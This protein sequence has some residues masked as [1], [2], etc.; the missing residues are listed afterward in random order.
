LSTIGKAFPV[1]LLRSRAGSLRASDA[2]GSGVGRQ[3]SGNTAQLRSATNVLS[4]VLKMLGS[5]YR[6]AAGAALSRCRALRPLDHADI[7]DA[8]GWRGRSG[9]R[10]RINNQRSL[11]GAWRRRPEGGAYI[12]LERILHGIAAG[13]HSSDPIA[14]C[15]G[16]CHVAKRVS[17]RSRKPGPPSRF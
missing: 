9:H 7:A 11:G 16:R 2:T 10:E 12:R 8:L 3:R 17:S 1:R 6:D 15:G 13:R 14:R 4:N 5:L